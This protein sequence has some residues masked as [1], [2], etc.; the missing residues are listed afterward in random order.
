MISPEQ[1]KKD[2]E[3]IEKY[4][5]GKNESGHLRTG[6]LPLESFAEPND[7]SRAGTKRFEDLAVPM[8]FIYNKNDNTQQLGGGY[9][10]K[11]SKKEDANLIDNE[12][13]YKLFGA[14]CHTKFLAKMGMMG[15]KQ[16]ST[17]KRRY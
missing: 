2:K 9:K 5:Y 13:F 12:L 17:K 1:H 4:I 6:G 16:N 15:G 3:F 8:G 10:I 7:Y 14:V 11:E